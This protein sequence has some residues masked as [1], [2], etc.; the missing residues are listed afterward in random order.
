MSTGVGAENSELK[1]IYILIQL[2]I[3]TLDVGQ[4]INI[5]QPAVESLIYS[6]FISVRVI[7]ARCH[8]ASAHSRGQLSCYRYVRRP[9]LM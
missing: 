3:F 4:R 1:S 7:F 9:L 8:T 5:T 2:Y 6:I